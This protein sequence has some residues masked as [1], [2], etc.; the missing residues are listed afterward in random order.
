MKKIK[1]GMALIIFVLLVLT[2]FCGAKWLKN[3]RKYNELKIINDE[4]ALLKEEIKTYEIAIQD[5]KLA[6]GEEVSNK[7]KIDELNSKIAKL[8]KE[9]DNYNNDINRLNKELGIK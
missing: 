7:K 5:F 2:T 1:I 8:N 9:I 6:K 4:Y 3:Y